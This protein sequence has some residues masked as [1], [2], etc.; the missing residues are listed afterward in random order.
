MTNLK[1]IFLSAPH[2][3]GEELAYIQKAF[4]TNWI[5]PAGPFITEF[6]SEFAKRVNGNYAVAVGTGT[7]AIHLALRLLNIALDDEVLC[8]TFTFIATANPIMYQG[9]KPVF[10]DVAADTWHIDLNLLAEFLRKRSNMNRL[11]KALIVPHIFGSAADMDGL[12]EICGQYEMPVIED[13]AE[14]I[15]TL[16]KD[17][18]PGTLTDIGTYSFNGNKI[19]TTSS[20][21]MLVCSSD[22]LAKR[23]RHL[24]TQARHLPYAFDHDDVGYNYRMSNILAGIGLGQLKVLND[25]VAKKQAINQMYKEQLSDIE[26][27]AFM[28]ITP[29]VVSTHW[30]TCITLDPARITVSPMDLIKALEAHNIESRLLWTPLHTQ[31]P[32]LGFERVEGEV[33]EAIFAKGVCLPSSYNMSEADQEYVIGVIRKVLASASVMKDS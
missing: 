9:A 2:M 8:S 13:A 1:K 4:D 21:G 28:P 23:A 31:K 10:I 15:G 33:S 17:R 25:H 6:E 30:L 12:L 18:A 16:Y 24:S 26:G 5:A 20:G 32:F 27:L 22:E 3:G 29:G 19:I 14:A 11:P 7:A